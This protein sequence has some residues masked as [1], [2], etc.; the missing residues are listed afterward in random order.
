MTPKKPDSNEPLSTVKGMRDI[1]GEDFYALQGFFEKASE[2]ALYYGFTPIDTPM[3]EKTALFERG[4]GQATDIVDK[5]MYSFKTRGGD[6]VSLRPELTPAI[7]RSYFET[8]M[9]SQPQ[10][11]LLYSYGPLFR[12]DRPQKGRYRQFYQFNVDAIGT[13]KSIADAMTIKILLT[14]LE[15]AG[16]KNLT[17]QLN[18]IGDKECRPIY[19]REL[20]N[21]YKKNLRQ[22]CPD[23]RER[24]K[25]N[26][27]R[28]LDCKNP[29]CQ[30]IKQA[31]P[32]SISYLCGSCKSHFKEVLEY[33]E[34][35]GIPYEINHS[36]VR[37]LDYYSRTVFEIIDPA[38]TSEPSGDE[39]G[40][41]LTIAGGGRYDYLARSLGSKKDLP[42]VGGAIGVDRM[43]LSPNYQRQDP[44]I[45]KKPKV[46]FIQLSFD[47]K[48]KSI[49]VIEI[50][51]KA[52]I[53]MAQSLSKD[54]LGIQLGIAE[55]MGVPYTLI[56]GQ[57]EALE[58]TVIVRNMTTRSQDIVS[59]AKLADYVKHLK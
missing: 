55:K 29:K 44:R 1:I 56:L 34:E 23:C 16:L 49:P 59:V 7:M 40:Q 10:P 19:R 32:T 6:E 57:K 9:Q 15:E 25:T 12:H 17:V 37:G 18:S 14:I 31:A 45:L 22:I 27:L 51:R 13:G 38:V 43:M 3:L 53:P 41:P 24:L 30:E 35:M 52:R 11:V 4:T 47:A 42:A 21:Y 58:G 26:P 28:L 54:S 50:L 39:T 36:L 33:L 2:I 20:V 8:G 46:F 5:E 48:L